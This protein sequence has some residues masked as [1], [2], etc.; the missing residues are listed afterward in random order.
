[1][2]LGILARADKGGLGYQSLAVY[3]Y[4]KPAVTVVVDIGN[5]TRPPLAEG[6]YPGAPVV[7]WD[8][9]AALPDVADLFAECDVVWSAETFYDQ[10]LTRELE[11]RGVASVLQANPELFDGQYATAYW[12]PTSWMLDWLPEGTRVVEM[13]APVDQYPEAVL[14]EPF[15]VVHPA[16]MPAAADRNGTQIVASARRVLEGKGY[17]LDLVGPEGSTR[18]IPVRFVDDPRDRD[19]GAAVCVLPRRY[20]GLS[21]PAIEA[22]CAGVPVVMP[23]VVPNSLWAQLTTSPRRHAGVSV[24]GGL[25]P[26]VHTDPSELASVVD[27]L[28]SDRRRLEGLRGEARG[29]AEAHSWARTGWRWLEALDGVNKHS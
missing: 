3:T 16:G 18:G 22:L 6:W 29:W 9:K 11:K 8:H 7:K 17:R 2:R 27:G 13:P 4:L 25:V 5:R 15:R 24:K 28:L 1:M 14:E 10:G 26:A 19:L 20:G 21:L 12:A 23:D